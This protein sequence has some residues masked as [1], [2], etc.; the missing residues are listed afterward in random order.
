MKLVILLGQSGDSVNLRVGD[1]M[2]VG[3]KML[4]EVCPV[5]RSQPLALRG[6][7]LCPLAQR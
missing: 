6:H 3:G 5:V 2:L 4:R 7:K 1:K